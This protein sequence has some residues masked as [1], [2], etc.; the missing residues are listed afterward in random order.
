M[1]IQFPDLGRWILSKGWNSLRPK[2]LCPLASKAH[3]CFLQH[4]LLPGH[5]IPKVLVLV[6]YCP[7]G[8][9]WLPTLPWIVSLTMAPGVAAAVPG[10]HLTSLLKDSQQQRGD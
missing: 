8:S 1:G 9:R 2:P 7:R 6:L 5:G 4:M 3:S 10:A